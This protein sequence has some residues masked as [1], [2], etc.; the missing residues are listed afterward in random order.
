MVRA[1]AVLTVVVGVVVLTRGAPTPP[2]VDLRE[3]KET[4]LLLGRFV[5]VY[6]VGVLVAG[7]FTHWTRPASASSPRC[8]SR[9]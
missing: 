5:A 2:G 7:L 9:C 3:R 6:V 8:S 1:I 4:V